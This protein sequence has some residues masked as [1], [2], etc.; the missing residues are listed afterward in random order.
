MAKRYCFATREELVELLAE[1]AHEGWMTSKREQGTTSRLA[2][3][4]EEFMRPYAELSDQAKDIDR[5]TVRAVLASLE[6]RGADVG[7]LV[8]ILVDEV[9]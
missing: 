4:G 7:A 1:D 9:V 5:A 2:E 3:W 8:K 6:A